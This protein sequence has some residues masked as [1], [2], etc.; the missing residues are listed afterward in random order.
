MGKGE[1]IL[2]ILRKELLNGM[3][4]AGSKFSSEQKLMIRFNVARPTIN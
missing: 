2:E 3:Y 4:K 1:D